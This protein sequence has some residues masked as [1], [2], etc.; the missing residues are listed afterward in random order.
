M[1]SL[2]STAADTPVLKSGYAATLPNPATERTAIPASTDAW[3]DFS[4]YQAKRYLP[5]L[6]G[7]RG[8]AVALVITRHLHRRMWDFLSGSVGVTIF[9]ILSGY[10]ITRLALKEERETGKLDLT[11]FYLRRSFRIFPM[12]YLVLALYA[13]LILGTHLMPAKAATLPTLLPYYLTYLQELPVWHLVHLPAGDLPFYQSWSLGIEEKFYLVWPILMVALGTSRPALRA[14]VALLLAAACVVQGMFVEGHT[15]YSLEHYAPILFGVVL[16][17]ALSA[18]ST[19]ERITSWARRL[20]TPSIIVALVTQFI[21]MPYSSA[22]GLFIL[23][24]LAATVLLAALV[25]SRGSAVRFLSTPALTLLGRISYGVY[26][27][28]VLC[29]FVVERFL[30]PERG[31]WVGVLAYLTTLLLSAV[32]AYVLH[33][34]FEKPLVSLGRRL[35]RK[36]IAV[37]GFAAP[38]EAT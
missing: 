6:D 30:K 35:S 20:L 23:Y 34:S 37:E 11:A 12:Y 10:L 38:I 32:L 19:Y 36:K 28:H 29:L 17:L 2:L 13:G 22:R 9:F 27:L 24:A 5:A 8:I 21:L 31:P 18:P 7:L 4:T 14:T 26:L 1:S 15:A 33:I 3:L 16:A 25:T